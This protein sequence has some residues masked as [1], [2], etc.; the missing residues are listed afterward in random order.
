[1]A[2]EYSVETCKRLGRAF[3]RQNVE[4]PL[5]ITRYDPGDELTYEVTGVCPA[6]RATVRLA[7]E[8]FV[9]GGFAGQVYRVKVLDVAGEA[10]A[11]LTPGATC[12]MKVLVP[13]SGFSELFRNAVYAVGFQGPFSLQVN[14]DAVRAGALWQKLI[15]RAATLRFGD[16]RAVVDILATLHDRNLGSFGELSEWVDGRNWRFEVDDHLD[17]RAKSL[18]GKP[19]DES[20]LGSPE[21]RAKRTFM[22]EFVELLGE[23]GAHE[24]ARQYQWWT[25]K[26]QPNVL[27]RTDRE[28]DPAAGLTAVDFR[29]GL[30]LLPFLPMSPG[31]VALIGRGVARG[32][33][34]QF[35]RGDLAKLRG[36]ISAR[37]G[38]FA[39][40]ADALAELEQ[41]EAAYR[42]SLPDVTHHHVRLLHDGRLWSRIFDANVEA[43][44]RRN[45]VDA[46]FAETL[47]RRRFAAAWFVLLGLVPL[48]GRRIQKLV[49]RADVRRHYARLLDEAGYLRR[50]VAAHI[51][52]A[53]IGWHRDGRIDA[54]HVEALARRPLGPRAVGFALHAVLSVLPAG[55]HRALT[56]AAYARDKLA[57]VFVRPIRLLFDAALREQWMRDMI[58]DGE[59]KGMVTPAEAEGIRGRLSE[60]YVQKYLQSLAVHVMTLP[61]T[62]IVSVSVAIWYKIAND[63]TWGQAWDEMLLII[64]LF[65]VP[66]ISPGSICRGLYVVYLVI[67][68]R[69]I[70]DYNIAVFMG[71]FKYIG[72]LSFP[73]QMAYRYPVLARFMA[74]HWATE[75]VHAVPVFGE[76][77]ALLEHGVFDL[78]YNRLLTIRR[79]FGESDAARAALR[80]RYWHVVPC[81]LAAAG[82]FAAAEAIGYR[83]NAALPT[84]KQLWPLVLIVPTAAAGA[85]AALARGAPVGRRILLGTVCGAAAGAV[86]GVIRLVGGIAVGGLLVEDGFESGLNCLAAVLWPVLLF[87]LLAALGAFIVETRLEKHQ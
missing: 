24:F 27:K 87:S 21:Y 51:A 62:Q 78:C 44:A 63:L 39:D 10:V 26:S 11:G 79:R 17:L 77:G 83:V 20:G 57:T 12:A 38:N 18:A 4:R 31:D 2:G 73:V 52:E 30:A 85:V 40:L 32:S 19:V 5:K 65:Q 56:D 49:G 81:V 80:P 48:L 42:E 67:R 59:A 8:R 13:P 70:K 43:L 36:F 69:N 22:R 84:L 1:L 14:L 75:L 64:G 58:A 82:V 16:E 33:L 66:P 71:F 6:A 34:V 3:E 15:R 72:Y 41:R 74:G 47:R 55:L 25:C 53:L 50:A 46:P 54:E 28:D 76:R 23:M 61:V 35:D 37:E 45:T 68:E 60:P 86:Y 7:V 29:A 9:G